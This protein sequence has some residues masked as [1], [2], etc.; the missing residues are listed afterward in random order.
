M[1]INILYFLNHN[2]HKF[3]IPNPLNMYF[4]VDIMLFCNYNDNMQS[5]NK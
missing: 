4:N 5:M 2:Y 3:G 1:N